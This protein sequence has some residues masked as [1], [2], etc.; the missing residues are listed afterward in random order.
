[1]YRNA[2]NSYLP[3]REHK[4]TQTEYDKGFDHGYD[5]ALKQM[6]LELRLKRKQN[7]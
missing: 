6:I 5:W 3:D 7:K 2:G 1:M 4:M